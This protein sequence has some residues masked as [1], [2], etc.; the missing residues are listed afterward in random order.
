MIFFEF[1]SLYRQ[2]MVFSVSYKSIQFFIYVF[3]MFWL[4]SIV[5][6][7][8]PALKDS[9]GLHL[10][11]Y[12]V[13]LNRCH[14]FIFNINQ[15]KTLL[16]QSICAKSAFD[17]KFPYFATIAILE[18]SEKFPP[19]NSV[20][21][22]KLSNDI[23]YNEAPISYTTLIVYSMCILCKKKYL[24]SNNTIWPNNQIIVRLCF[25]SNPSMLLSGLKQTRIWSEIRIILSNISRVAPRIRLGN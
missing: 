6:P 12:I 13:P 10:F 5:S 15:I 9:F 24:A 25:S 19:A 14:C 2:V 16:F 17:N 20:V 23:T 8:W 11:F 4:D 1:L 18:F 7:K 3:Q 21:Y 22:D